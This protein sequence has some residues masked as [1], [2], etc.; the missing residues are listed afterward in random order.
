M[1]VDDVKTTGER[2]EKL[3]KRSEIVRML[4]EYERVRRR[5]LGLVASENVISPAALRACMSDPAHRYTLPPPE[6]RS[7]EIWDY[8]NQLQLNRIERRL[9]EMAMELFGARYVDVRPLSGNNA[10]FCVLAAL[11]GRGDRVLRVPDGCGGYFSTAPIAALRGVEL[12]DIPYD[13]ERGEVDIEALC[14]LHRKTRP[15]LVL[16]AA[17]MMTFTLPLREIRSALGRE[18]V[19]SYDVSHPL[20]IIGGGGFQNPLAGGARI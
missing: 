20:G 16:F 15:A 6:E 5:S 8:P 7:V 4:D 10:V 2:H 13:R 9:Q 12:V 11:A 14:R 18:A 1:I 19:I 3:R 17:S